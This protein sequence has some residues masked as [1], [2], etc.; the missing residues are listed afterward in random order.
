MF[1]NFVG[2]ARIFHFNIGHFISPL[3]EHYVDLTISILYNEAKE[4]TRT[5]IESCLFKK[6]IYEKKKN[7]I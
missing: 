5:K 7:R 3:F 6:E 2:F 1:S 4:S